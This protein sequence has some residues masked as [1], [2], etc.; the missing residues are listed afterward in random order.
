V[1]VRIS[2]AGGLSFLFDGLESWES[3]G[4]WGE[5]ADIGSRGRDERR[6][7]NGK[8]E[9]KRREKKK[10]KEKSLIPCSS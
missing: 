1:E 9:R 5:D 4:E 7:E 6:A 3:K 8:A 10:E 2:R